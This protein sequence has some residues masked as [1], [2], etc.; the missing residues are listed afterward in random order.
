MDSFIALQHETIALGPAH[1]FNMSV[2]PS[3]VAE[4]ET[5]QVIN[6]LEANLRTMHITADWPPSY[7]DLKDV[8]VLASQDVMA[9][10]GGIDANNSAATQQYLC[11]LFARQC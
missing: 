3:A 9:A 5:K 11:H 7:F 10:L 2:H 4:H 8:V 6:G 1:I